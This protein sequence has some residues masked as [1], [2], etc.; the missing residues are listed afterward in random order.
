MK[1]YT[2]YPG[3]YCPAGGAE[4]IADEMNEPTVSDGARPLLNMN[5][6]DNYFLIDMVLPG[7]RRDDIIL[8]VH[9]GILS[10]MV[11][12]KQRT[13]TEKNTLQI[14]EFDASYLKRNI[15][16]PSNADSVFINAVYEDGILHLVVPKASH[17]AIS[18]PTRIIIY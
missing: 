12:C 7:I 1:E 3:E 8:Q 16:L 11:A 4:L 15:M 5:E 18:T 17:P 6:F 9:D 13:H 14:H 10:I 2:V